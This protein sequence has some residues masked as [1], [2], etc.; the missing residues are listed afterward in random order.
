[1]DT[2]EYYRREGEEVVNVAKTFSHVWKSRNWGDT[3]KAAL[4][5]PLMIAEDVD[6]SDVPQIKNPGRL[7]RPD[8]PVPINKATLRYFMDLA[9]AAYGFPG[10]SPLLTDFGEVLHC[11]RCI[12]IFIPNFSII[13]PKSDCPYLYPAGS[14]VLLV[15][16]GTMSFSDVFTDIAATK[17]PWPGTRTDVGEVHDGFMNAARSILDDAYDRYLASYD[18]I[19][20]VGHSLGAGVAT[21]VSMLLR[22]RGKSTFCW[23]FAPP[24]SLERK[25]AA[26]EPDLIS[27]VHRADAVPRATALSFEI[28]L[29]RAAEKGDLGKGVLRDAANQVSPE[30][31]PKKQNLTKKPVYRDE[32]HFLGGRV[33]LKIGNEFEEMT[34]EE[35]LLPRLLAT[36]TMI[37]DHF[38]PNYLFEP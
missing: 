34:P 14:N 10:I 30:S 13:A 19:T 6:A 16:R 28:L 35:P 2:L 18:H 27:V 12:D 32:R 21:Y 23:A 33:L 5:L 37:L 11:R 3:P 20:V 29:D 25:T 17:V 31:P 1:M 26:E 36:R 15:I 8:G 4:G 38:P 24:P 7:L 22:E 9:H